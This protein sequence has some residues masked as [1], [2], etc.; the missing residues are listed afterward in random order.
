MIYGLSDK[1]KLLRV[2]HK[3]SQT[4]VADR[5]QVA[6]ATI[7]SYETGERTPSLENLVALAN[8]YRVST[9]FLL[10]VTQSKD[11]ALLNTSKLNKQQLL[12]LQAL[13]DSIE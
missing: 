3:L 6:P 2:Q 1:L 8:L 10:G 5:I 12:A 11:T 7:S 4:E 9:D 13:I